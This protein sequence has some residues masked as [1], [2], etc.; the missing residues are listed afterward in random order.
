MEIW[1]CEQETQIKKVKQF[2][3]NPVFELKIQFEGIEYL[4]EKVK[5]L[6]EKQVL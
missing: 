3:F 4:I 2:L 1:Q 6:I 5:D